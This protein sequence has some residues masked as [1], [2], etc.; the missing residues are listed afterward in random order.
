MIWVQYILFRKTYSYSSP[1]DMAMEISSDNGKLKEGI[2]AEMW[3]TAYCMGGV[4]GWSMSS[5]WETPVRIR[6][7]GSLWWCRDCMLFSYAMLTYLLYY[8]SNFTTC[9]VAHVSYV[10]FSCL[11]SRFYRAKLGFSARALSSESA[12]LVACAEAVAQG[13]VQRVNVTRPYTLTAL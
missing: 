6:T 11:L 3:R 7:K 2:L 13:V 8:Y 5:K 10:I 12:A 1:T 4:L 9:T